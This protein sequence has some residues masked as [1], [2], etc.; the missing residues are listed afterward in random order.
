MNKFKKNE[1]Y[2]HNP[3]QSQT[4]WLKKYKFNL[5]FLQKND[6]CGLYEYYIPNF[7]SLDEIQNIRIALP[8]LT[9]P[10]FVILFGLSKKKTGNFEPEIFPNFL[11]VTDEL[12]GRIFGIWQHFLVALDRLQ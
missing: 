6:F 1:N 7:F 3:N 2:S 11:P 9:L 10:P 4:E 12:C 5:I 8:L